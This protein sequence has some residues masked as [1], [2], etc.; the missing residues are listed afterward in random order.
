MR[1]LDNILNNLVVLIFHEI[2]K[3]ILRFKKIKWTKKKLSF[4]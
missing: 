4:Q 3:F 2:M 1:Y